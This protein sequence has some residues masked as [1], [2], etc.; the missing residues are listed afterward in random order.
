MIYLIRHAQ[1]ID[2]SVHSKLT[3]KGLYDSFLYGKRLKFD[4]IKIDLIVSSPIERCIQTAQKI[5]EGYGKICIEESTLLGNPGIFINNSN[6]AM[7]IFNKHELRDIINMQLSMQ[8]LDGFNKI[9]IATQTL[10]SFMTSKTDNILYITHDAII[11]PFINFIENIN[12]IN[13]NDMVDYLHGYCN[14]YKHLTHPWKKIKIDSA[15]F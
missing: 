9:D 1:K 13:K 6:N 5:S 4:N 2:S 14:H 10:L 3:E 11:L 8:E 12:N 7:E 15:K